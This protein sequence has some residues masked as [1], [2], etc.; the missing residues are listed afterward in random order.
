M[1]IYIN[2]IIQLLI[3]ILHVNDK[4]MKQIPISETFVFYSVFIMHL[5]PEA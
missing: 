1:L 5:R 3:N 4:L 2:N